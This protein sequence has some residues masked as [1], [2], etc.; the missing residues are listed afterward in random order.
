M[1]N[2]IYFLLI[3]LTIISGCSQ[4]HTSPNNAATPLVAVSIVPQEWFV[5][6]IGAGRA[7]TLVLAGP[8]QNPHNYEPTPRQV[9][10]LARAGA[11]VLS[12]AEFEVTLRP[13]VEKLFPALPVIDGA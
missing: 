10:G 11:W 4:R 12:G 13:K 2:K 9:S 1:I 8:G 6:R 5:S 7:Q 3:L